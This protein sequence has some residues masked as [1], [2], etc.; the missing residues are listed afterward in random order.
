ME[1]PN[2]NVIQINSFMNCS[3]TLLIGYGHIAPK[4]DGKSFRLVILNRIYLTHILSFTF[5]LM[6]GIH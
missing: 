5:L 3:C 4:T 1:L 6:I 2:Q